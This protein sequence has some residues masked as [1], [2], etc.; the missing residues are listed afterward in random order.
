M[1]CDIH[2]IVEIRK[3]GSWKY[4]DDLP[5]VF[6]RRH[7]NLFS[8]LCSTVRRGSFVGGFEP[9][10]LPADLSGR[11][12]RFMSSMPT[13]KSAYESGETLVC[14]IEAENRYISPI[15]D[16]LYEYIN[17]ELYESIVQDNT[18]RVAR[19]YYLPVKTFDKYC[20]YDAGKVG[21]V[22]VKKSYRDIF[23]TIGEFNKEYYCFPWRDA[24]QDYGYYDVDFDDTDYHSGSY[25]TLAELNTKVSSTGDDDLFV[26]PTDFLNCLMGEIG[27]LPETFVI[28]ELDANTS[29]V[30]FVAD[31]EMLHA[32][33]CY[34]E[35][36]ADLC[37]IKEKYGI[38]EDD[39]IRIVFA[40]DF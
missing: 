18:E 16:C 4:V 26:V 3:N 32:R 15:S 33:E 7:Y 13:L 30:Y 24:E 38:Q 27:E 23:P 35:G 37:R 12:F 20:V 34:N 2:T 14:W 22:F 28:Q 19:R 9:K 8:M 29:Q 10:G 39:D 5:E 31:P 1:G 36:V 11:R 25:L 21:G 6:D 40:F 17:K